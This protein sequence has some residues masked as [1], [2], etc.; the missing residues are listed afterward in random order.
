MNAGWNATFPSRFPL[1]ETTTAAAPRRLG[2]LRPDVVY[3]HKM[4]DLVG[5]R[6][7]R[8]ERTPLV[9]MV[10]DHDIYCMRSYKY[11]YFTRKIC[12]R[13]ASPYCIFPCLASVVRNPAAGSPQVGQLLRQKAR[14]R[15][16][17]ALPPH[18]RRHHLHAR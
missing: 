1:G 13:A 10:H 16:Q 14:D 2:F 5:D 18:G 9:R 8:S 15:P 17:P 3:V 6:G 12:T 4:A 11:N 7:P